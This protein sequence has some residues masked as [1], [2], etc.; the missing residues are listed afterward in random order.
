MPDVTTQFLM[1]VP[2]RR[3]I[4]GG[5]SAINVLPPSTNPVTSPGWNAPGAPETIDVHYP[6][7]SSPAHP[8]NFAFW[9]VVGSADG[10]FTDRPTDPAN[11]IHVN[12]DP[13]TPM[14]ATAWYI[15]AG[16][17][18]GNGNGSELETD[19]FLVDENQFVDPTP[20]DSVN[21]AAAWDPSDVREFVFTSQASDVEALDSVVDPHEHFETWYALEGGSTPGAGRSLHVPQDDNGIA[22]ATYRVPPPT[23]FKPPREPG[24]GGTIVGGVARDGSGGIIIGGHYHPI[25]PWDPFLA[26]LAVFAAAKALQPAAREAVQIEAMRA[27]AGEA[28]NIEQRLRAGGGG[29]LQ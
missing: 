28:Q 21:P 26:A 19:A 7:P 27:I 11:S 23:P 9:S 17:G 29:A 3:R 1:F 25:G 4:G 24:L 20:I 2:R 14:T 10:E 12:L 8:A 6:N 5:G 18:N 15:Y 22:V 13:G 16:G